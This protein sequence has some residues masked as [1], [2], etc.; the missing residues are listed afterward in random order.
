MCHTVLPL[1]GLEN[2]FDPLSLG[3]SPKNQTDVV[4]H[5]F[6]PDCRVSVNSEGIKG[7]GHLS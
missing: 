1:P 5:L 2:V 4:M 7:N 6:S 3:L